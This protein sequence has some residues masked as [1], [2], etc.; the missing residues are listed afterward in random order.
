MSKITRSR[1]NMG[2]T[3]TVGQWLTLHAEEC[4]QTTVPEIKKRLAADTGITVTEDS[5]R[6][7]LQTCKI[8]PKRQK[9]SGE[10]TDRTGVV[11]RSV[12]EILQ[13][14]GM[15]VSEDL[16]SVAMRRKIQD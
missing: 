1:L 16:R 12:I 9:V 8:T 5:L 11:A 6:S 4:S 3:I 2:Q 14:L 13:Q 10:L 7:M 15:P